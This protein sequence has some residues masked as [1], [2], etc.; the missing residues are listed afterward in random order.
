MVSNTPIIIGIIIGIFIC[1]YIHN[2]IKTPSLSNFIEPYIIFGTIMCL[3]VFIYLS[4]KI[5]HIQIIKKI[6]FHFL[7]E[8]L[9]LGLFSY[10]YFFMIYYFRGIRIKKM[11]IIYLSLLFVVFHILL[12]LSGTYKY[13]F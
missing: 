5:F 6:P 13:F 9:F 7:L 12:E 10:I 8:L 3:V 4:L 2:F 1:L 11:N